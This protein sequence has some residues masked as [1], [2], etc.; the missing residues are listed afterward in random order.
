MDRSAQNHHSH[1]GARPRLFIVP[2]EHGAWAMW[3]VPGVVGAGLAGTGYGISALLMVAVLLLFWAR[4]PLWLW[5]RSRSRTLP[6]GAIP[7]MLTTGIAGAGIVVGLA[8]AYERWSLFVF[9]AMVS[10]ALLANI[11]LV[12]AGGE[13]SLVGE[14]IG[15]AS[16]GLTGPA[17][18]YSATGLLD[19]QVF[20]AWLLPALFFGT[21]VFA[22]KLRV[23]GYA[24]V[25]SGRS[26]VALIGTLVG[27][28][29]A[30]LAAVAVWC[31][32]EVT[33]FPALVAY[34]PVT[35]QAVWSIRGLDTPPKLMRLG[36]LW[37]AHSVLYTVLLLALA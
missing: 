15:I 8:V 17:V 6:D 9:A 35:V 16:L 32:F 22:V 5:A 10:V 37:V 1:L 27:Y 4:Y 21:S 13:R 2:R 33:A 28:Q 3:I 36:W 30:A 29:V 26:Q 23:E 18:Y 14:F 19:A 12:M 20:A 11:R 31:A 34:A 7:T 25:K 24:R